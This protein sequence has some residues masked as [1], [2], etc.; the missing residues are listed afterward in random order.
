MSTEV[1][2]LG[3]E[4]RVPWRE[5]KEWPELMLVLRQPFSTAATDRMAPYLYQQLFDC[6]RIEPGKH[7]A[8]SRALTNPWLARATRLRQL[9]ILPHPEDLLSRDTVLE[10]PMQRISLPR[11]QLFDNRRLTHSLLVAYQARLAAQALNLSPEDQA[12]V[13]AAGLQH[14]LGHAALS[15]V[16]DIVLDQLDGTDHETRSVNTLMPNYEGVARGVHDTLDSER[17][18]ELDKFLS[19]LAAIMTEKPGL[20]QIIKVIDTASY[21]QVD[22]LEAGLDIG[23]ASLV[24]QFGTNIHLDQSTGL[25][26]VNAEGQAAIVDLLNARRRAYARLY[27]HPY[28]LIAEAMHVKGL[29]RLIQGGIITRDDLKT[30]GDDDIYGAILTEALLD[31]VSG[32][33][34]GG[35]FPA[36]TTVS[37][38]IYQPI[39]YFPPVDV[40]GMNLEVVETKVQKNLGIARE[41]FVV[42]LPQDPGRKT[43]QVITVNNS[44]NEGVEEL[45]AT[46]SRTYHPLQDRVIIA[47]RNDAAA[48]IKGKDFGFTIS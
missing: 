2:G 25:L 35:F 39:D 7:I 46:D 29:K 48:K 30:K 40:E 8:L 12:L 18:T 13:A 10:T 16:G 6:S 19:E 4:Q 26:R 17:K 3:Y 33:L 36:A 1:G 38:G 42:V 15:H 47:A 27:T 43:V 31:P 45:R 44:G 24:S 11:F 21:L 14:D 20:G 23:A 5:I 9:G 22:S 32:Q 34:F 41:D 37:R 28:S